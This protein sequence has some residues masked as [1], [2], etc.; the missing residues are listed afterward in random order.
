MKKMI[1]FVFAGYAS[2]TCAYDLAHHIDLT[3]EQK[4]EI[5]T[6]H[7]LPW[8]G[9]GA[10]VLPAYK[11]AK[12]IQ[13]KLGKNKLSIAN[14]G[15]IEEENKDA[16]FLLNIKEYAQNDI[17]RSMSDTDR[18]GTHMK[19]ISSDVG[20]GYD[21]KGVPSS[22][23]SYV[24]G[25][26]ALGAY[27]DNIGW[28]GAI[29]FFEPR[30][31]ENVVCSYAESNLTLTGGTATIAQEVASYAVNNKLSVVETIGD[32]KSAFAYTVEWYDDAFRRI[33]ICAQPYF[34]KAN[35]NKIIDMARAIDLTI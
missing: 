23:V 15:Y 1:G 3:D 27:I 16:V 12:S 26:A 6:K 25:Y 34:V 29:E 2:M 11:M 17:Q 5:F 18:R 10:Q 13:E 19:L 4:N 30:E 20:V 35:V 33:L 31:L 7:G 22:I 32:S 21:Y 24:I 14:K 8:P 9:M 28:T